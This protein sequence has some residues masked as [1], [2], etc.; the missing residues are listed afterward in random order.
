M[1]FFK[2]PFDPNTRLG[3]RCACG[4][5]NS[6]AEHDQQLAV[7]QMEERAVENAVMHALFPNDQLRRNFLRA[8]G[9]G[10][11][12]AAIGSLFPLAA[13]KEAGLVSGYPDGSFRADQSITRQDATVL[14]GNAITFLQLQGQGTQADADK[15]LS[16]YTDKDQVAGYAQSAVGVA[17]ALGILQGSGDGTFHPLRTATRAETV[18]MMKRLMDLAGFITSE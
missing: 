5:H 13:A 10:T 8:V 1:S 12:M 17:S 14:L 3:M 7:Q 15:A 2:N 4:Q 6:Q 9:S 18:V 16:H 11:A